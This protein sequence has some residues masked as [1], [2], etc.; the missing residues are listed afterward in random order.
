MTAEESRQHRAIRLRNVLER[1][2]LT[3]LVLRSPPSFAWLTAG[4]D[5]RVDHASSTGVASIV[6]RATGEPVVLTTNIEAARMR[7]EVTPGLEVIEQAWQEPMDGMVRSVGGSRIGSDV[8]LGEE[9]D[10]ADEVK[11]VRCVLDEHAVGQLREVGRAAGAAADTA[12]REVVRG[13]TEYEIAALVAAACRPRGLFTPLLRVAVDGRKASQRQPVALG[14]THLRRAQIVVRAERFGAYANFTRVVDIEP[15]QAQLQRRHDAC[16]AILRRLREESTLP[17]RSLADVVDD[18]GRFYRE[19][20][21]PGQER[22][23]HQ[24]GL[25]GYASREVIATPS[26]RE[27]IQAGHAFAWNPSITGAKAEETF[28]LLESGAEVVAR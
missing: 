6:V 16:I 10:A 4:A 2:G 15:P 21:F 11:R 9:V 5:N 14:A 12:L 3:A 24:G 1:L 19:A 18:C 23:H 27:I 28:V 22:L 7:E 20:G 26:S 25:T 17:G 13:I 8:P